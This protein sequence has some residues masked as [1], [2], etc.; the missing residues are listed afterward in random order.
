[1]KRRYKILL[2]ATGIICSL[3]LCWN[4]SQFMGKINKISENPLKEISRETEDVPSYIS[5]GTLYSEFGELS[6]RDICAQNGEQIFLKEVLCIKDKKVYFIY[7]NTERS[8]YWAIGSVDYNTQEFESIGQLVVPKDSYYNRSGNNLKY[9][10]W[11]GYYYD[12]KIVLTDHKRLLEYDIFSDELKKYD[13]DTY[14]FPERKI[15]GK[16]IDNE[17][18]ELIINGNSKIYT[19]EQMAESSD[20]I[21]EVYQLKNEKIWN[22]ESCLQHFFS[23]DSIQVVQEKVYTIGRWMNY[24]G[25]S[26]AVMFFYDQENDTWK[27]VKSWHTG[28]I[29][30][31]RCYVIPMI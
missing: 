27:Y 25:E 4:F 7:S 12:K 23:V 14:V 8:Y 10:E 6:I 21:A 24:L 5:Y 18:I 29:P 17:T 15:Y 31:G 19:L 11:N 30:S 26:S 16:Y 22:D 9:N 13:Y 20:G 28:D 2:V 1:M 3:L